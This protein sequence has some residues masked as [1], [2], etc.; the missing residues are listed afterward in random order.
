[1]LHLIVVCWICKGHKKHIFGSG[2]IGGGG[3]K[4]W[5]F[6][7]TLLETVIAWPKG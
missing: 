4:V 5:V 2:S 7:N 3:K 1:M 6:V